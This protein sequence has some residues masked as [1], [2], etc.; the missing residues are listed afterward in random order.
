M[1]IEEQNFRAK[2]GIA[3]SINAGA[4]FV[5]CGVSQAAGRIADVLQAFAGQAFDYG[6]HIEVVGLPL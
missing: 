2:A 4:W 5:G 6:G 1:G 3:N